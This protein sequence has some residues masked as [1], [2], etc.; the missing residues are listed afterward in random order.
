M[1]QYWSQKLSSSFSQQRCKS[2]EFPHFIPYR[3]HSICGL[4]PQT[5]RRSQAACV[6]EKPSDSWGS[7]REVP[8]PTSIWTVDE[9]VQ[10]L[11]PPDTAS[12]RSRCVTS[13]PTATQAVGGSILTWSRQSISGGQS[14]RAQDRIAVA[15]G[16][17]V[18]Y[19]PGGA[20]VHPQKYIG[21]TW[22]IHW[23]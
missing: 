3:M 12:A 5:A 23:A 13:R 16:S 11:W 17:V 18:V 8:H 14:N 15:H 20:N 21:P 9:P 19:W 10:C 4:L 6:C 1:L 7:Q 2:V 22:F